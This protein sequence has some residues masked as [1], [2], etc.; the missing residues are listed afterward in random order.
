MATDKQGYVQY[1]SANSL[2]VDD[3]LFTE[4][5]LF[6]NTVNIDGVSISAGAGITGGASTDVNGKGCNISF[7]TFMHIDFSLDEF[8]FDFQPSD[9]DTSLFDK[10]DAISLEFATINDML[11]NSILDMNCCDIAGTYNSTMVP[12]FQFF[13]DSNNGGEFI[14]MLVRFAE[15]ITAIRAI[16]E[17]LECLVRL[18]PGNPWF[19]FDVDWLMWIYGYFKEAKPFL[20]RILSGELLDIILNPV[21]NMRVKMQACL[22]SGVPSSEFSQILQIGSPEQLNLISQLAVK[23]GNTLIASE[24]PANPKPVKP[25]PSDYVGGTSNQEYQ[26][27]VEIYE[28]R[29]IE[30]G[31]AEKRRAI[32]LEEANRQ[33]K[34]QKNVNKH[35]AVTTQTNSLISA[36]TSGICGCVADALGLNN[37]GVELFPLRTTSDFNKLVGQTVKGVSNRAAGTT[38][39][40]NNAEDD[41]TLTSENIKKSKCRNAVIKGGSGPSGAGAK[42][43]KG[44]KSVAKSNPYSAIG[45]KT[46]SQIIAE[47]VKVT[48]QTGGTGSTCRTQCVSNNDASHKILEDLIREN[49]R[50]MDGLRQNLTI[51]EQKWVKERD[52]LK[53]KIEDEKQ[54]IA[55]LSVGSPEYVKRTIELG[56]ALDLYS[57]QF[58]AFKPFDL[59]NDPDDYAILS[60]YTNEELFWGLFPSKYWGTVRSMRS[61]TLAGLSNVIQAVPYPPNTPTQN[62][63]NDLPLSTSVET[64][65]RNYICY[66]N[67]GFVREKGSS[68][69]RNFNKLDIASNDQSEILGAIG[70]DKTTAYFRAIFPNETVGDTACITYSREEYSPNMKIPEYLE[71]ELN[72]NE[73]QNVEEVMTSLTVLYGFQPEDKL[74]ELDD[75]ELLKVINVIAETNGYELGKLWVKVRVADPGSQFTTNPNTGDAIEYTYSRVASNN[76]EITVNGQTLQNSSVELA[77]GIENQGAGGIAADARAHVNKAVQD[78]EPMFIKATKLN[79]QIQNIFSSID[80]TR[81]SIQ[82]SIAAYIPQKIHL[83]IPCTCDNFL[84][85][86]LNNIIQYVMSALNALIQQIIKM[87]IQYIIPDWVRS[88]LRMIKDFLSCIGAIF[89]IGKTIVEIHK[90]AED[91]LESM[92]DRVRLYPADPCYI[93]NPG[94]GNLNDL[95]LEYTWPQ[96]PEPPEYPP[97]PGGG[98]CDKAIENCGP[99]VIPGYPPII[100]PPPVTIKPGQRGRSYPAFRFECDYLEL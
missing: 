78:R 90:Y 58:N 56:V 3:A 17:P 73:P 64:D 76:F 60:S 33:S 72:N 22:H 47:C 46:D 85:M 89:G 32:Y 96:P 25:K 57:S 74:T 77:F 16:M 28:I 48:S 40:H 5:D 23:G 51:T 50:L 93:D 68:S 14:T 82:N 95:P 35:L 8:T 24:L 12:F 13:A 66:F 1:Y 84:C 71:A 87:I 10:A 34:L 88:L 20:D 15:V 63:I 55:K 18:V 86:L 53:K 19:P 49:Q 79:L 9:F 27:L 75:S 21:H 39:K 26:K 2:K 38:S 80:T 36:S 30:Y 7:E 37:I 70:K 69:W 83:N 67:A 91:L 99:I 65:E 59:K 29:I 41:V 45:A 98:G 62:I 97:P 94:G 54:N 43:T 100:V 52:I 42:C 61:S 4:Q 11:I 92:R 31:K 81:H 44:S 6:D